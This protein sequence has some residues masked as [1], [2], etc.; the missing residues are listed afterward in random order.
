MIHTFIKSTILALFYLS[1]FFSF[2]FP[3]NND[4][5]IGIAQGKDLQAVKDAAFQNLAQQIQVFISS[6]SSREM[7]EDNKIFKDSL[8]SLTVTQSFVSLTDVTE[9]IEKIENENFKVTKSV[10]KVNVQKMFDTRRKRILEYLGEADRLRQ[11]SQTK[12]SLSLQSI[13]NNYF[14][15]YLLNAI[16]PD[17][18]TYCFTTQATSLAVGIPN[19]IDEIAHAIEFVPVKQ[20]DD[21]YIVWK[22]KARYK[23]K[24]VLDFHYSFFDGM[25]Q[26]DGIVQRGETQMT[27]YYSSKEKIERQLQV[28][29]EFPSSEELDNTLGTAMKFVNTSVLQKTIPV[30]VPKDNNVSQPVPESKTVSQPVPESKTVPQP[31]P[32]EKTVSTS[33]HK[34]PKELDGLLKLPM[35]FESTINELKR[36]VKSGIIVQGRAS[37]F[38]SLNGLYGVVVDKPG[39]AGLLQNTK[40]KYYDFLSG[41]NVMLKD[42][43]GKRILWFDLLKK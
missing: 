23:G 9:K 30:F 40:N 36:L 38:E 13:L 3:Q 24:D 29:M 43:A 14:Q 21:E 6:K 2:L 25:G 19:I 42:F 39:L 11:D 27:L 20:I 7:R 22:Y 4:E 31:V 17:T 15:A 8:V 37:D 1:I 16:Y 32:E 28:Q 41:R 33:D 18:L 12:S 35:T 26:S 34:L 5:Y 10:S